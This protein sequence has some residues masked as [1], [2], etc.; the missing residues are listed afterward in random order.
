MRAHLC[1]SPFRVAEVYAVDVRTPLTD[2]AFPSP[3]RVIGFALHSRERQD[4]AEFFDDA[5]A[6]AVVAAAASR[7]ATTLPTSPPT[8][9]TAGESSATLADHHAAPGD[10][11]T[12]RERI[13]AASTPPSTSGFGGAPTETSRPPGTPIEGSTAAAGRSQRPG[14]GSLRGM[15]GTRETAVRVVGTCTTSDRGMLSLYG[16]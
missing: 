12:T 6:E 11:P 9:G 8:P 5:R 15:G 16:R 2:P 1:W 13:A 14:A 7:T 4:T 10:T 3:P